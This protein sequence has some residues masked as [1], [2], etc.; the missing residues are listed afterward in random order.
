MSKFFITG[1][2]VHHLTILLW[3]HVSNIYL[4]GEKEECERERESG[5][6]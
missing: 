2:I 6:S 3:D 1:N 4:I 5:D